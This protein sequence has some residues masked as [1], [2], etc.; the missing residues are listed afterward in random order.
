M[1]NKSQLQ[2]VLTE[3][4]KDFVSTHWEKEKYKWEAVKCFQD[5]WNVNDP[6]FAEMLSRS[7]AKTYNLLAS[8]NNFPK[9]MILT[10]AQKAPEVV[11]LMFISLFDES[12]DVIARIDEF[13]SLSDGLMKYD[14]TAKQHYQK[15]NAISI[16]LWLRY[17]DKYYIYKYSEVKEVA[18]KLANDS[19][20]KRGEYIDNLRVFYRLYDEICNELRNDQELVDLMK[21][22]IDESCYPDTELKTLTTDFGVYTSRYFKANTNTQETWYP[23][24]YSPELNEKDWLELLKDESVFNLSSLEIMKRLKHFNQP[25]TFSQLSMLFGESP[26]FYSSGSTSLA[27]RVSSKTECPIFENE[28]GVT[29]WW[30]ILYES[31]TVGK[32]DEVNIK[33]KL[34]E[35]LSDALEN[36][37]LTDVSLHVDETPAIWKIS[38]GTESTGI[39]DNLKKVFLERQVVVVHGT[40]KAKASSKVTQGES[41]LHSIKEGD[42]FY[43]CYGNSIQL[44]GRFNSNLVKENIE[45]KNQWFERSYDVI[46]PS[47]SAEAYTGVK[48]WWTP[49]DNSTCIKV[50]NF[51]LFERVI[52]E[53]YFDLTIN[54]LFEKEEK[55]L[56]YWWLSVNPKTWSTS[57]VAVGKVKSFP[58]HSESGKQRERFQN[59]LDA[60]PGDMVVIYEAHPVNKVVALGRISAEQDGEQIYVEKVEGL[61][62][63]IEF[64]DF[65]DYSELNDL[66]CHKSPQANLLSL[67]KLEYDFIFDLI[68]KDNP[69]LFDNQLEVYSKEN[70][71][72]E[73]FMA[74]DRY[75]LLVSVLKN[76]KNIIL[77]GAPGVGKT[78]AAKRL[79][80]SILEEKDDNCI[81]F[82]QFHQNYSYED[83]M[84]GYKPVE[85]GFELKYG[86]FYRFCQKA[87]NRPDREHFFIIDEINR[88]NMSKIFGELLMLIER[89]YR[90]S[91]ITLAYN[92]MSFS[93]PNNLHIIGMMNT[94]DRSLAMID[95]ALRRRFSFFEMEPGFD[96]E[97]FIKYQ[98]SLNDET[99]N[100]L[101][102]R[103]QELN[104]EI[105]KDRSLGKGFSIG[106]SYFCGQKECSEEWLHSI[107]EFDILPMLSEYW[108]DDLNKLN[109][110]TNMLRGVF[111]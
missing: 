79:A 103:T 104:K 96:T 30:P 85:D 39:S 97:G 109:H 1:I 93:V 91:K 81:E 6:D 83:F 7:L 76:K 35:E 73:V 110:W 106:H 77:Q 56:R 24:D 107:I 92:G 67:S 18:E 14:E 27:H 43:L 80:W 36:I 29:L 45:K 20:I 34:R 54:Q 111:Q 49:N 61:T 4:K 16:Y 41:F 65:K 17:P 11:R 33:M 87:A 62:Y 32:D 2:T 64:S 58:L 48:K 95:Y 15:V 46:K 89:D 94:A 108:F 5:N 13:R 25:V 8:M 71:L 63:P 84:M 99:L 28:N 51:D 9:G 100:D 98:R 42:Y 69:L 31:L 75:D 74:E 21:S 10:F 26:S 57:D 23:L 59:F 38:H 105:A 70:F 102:Q 60:K 78:F 47:R 40:T 66:E 88:G 101:V 19:S 3:Y 68:R 82:V 86:V 50:D 90:D 55:K 52:L 44:L 72:D 37:N 12:K 53:P 22:Q